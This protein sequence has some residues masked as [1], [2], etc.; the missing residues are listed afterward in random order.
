MDA[1]NDGRTIFERLTSALKECSEEELRRLCAKKGFSEV[2][3]TALLFAHAALHVADEQAA[4]DLFD[5]WTDLDLAVN[6]TTERERVFVEY[7]DVC[8]A[9]AF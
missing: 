2:E 1:A 5:R 3:T 8:V 9:W 4:L 7:A 6:V